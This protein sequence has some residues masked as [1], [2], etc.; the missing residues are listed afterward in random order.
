MRPAAWCR[1]FLSAIERGATIIEASREAGITRRIADHRR[2]RSIRF[3]AEVMRRR[4]IA[5]RARE[6][7]AQLE[8]PALCRRYAIPYNMGH[9]WK[10]IVLTPE[11][12]QVTRILHPGK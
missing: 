2:Q 12:Q 4:L 11:I 6:Y 3:T 1:P 5:Q 8:L 9:S 10:H 7:V